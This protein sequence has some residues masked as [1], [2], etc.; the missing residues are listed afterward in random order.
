M[1]TPERPD[2]YFVV[3]A[4]WNEEK[5]GYEFVMDDATLMARFHDG[6]A[7]DGEEWVTPEGNAHARDV[8]LA[9]QLG[10]HLTMLGAV[11]PSATLE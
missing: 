6:Q 7:W 9:L 2:H 8:S 10:D 4:V 5:Q 11:K 3:A 1:A